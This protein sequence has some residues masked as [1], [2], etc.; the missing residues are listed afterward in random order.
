MRAS[1]LLPILDAGEYAVRERGSVRE[2]KMSG[3]NIRCAGR[4]E[5]RTKEREHP[6]C[7]PLSCGGDA[8]RIMWLGVEE[9][10]VFTALVPTTAFTGGNPAG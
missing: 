10:L 7:L 8:G 9:S 1:L 3:W 2:G 4:Y 6:C 5:A